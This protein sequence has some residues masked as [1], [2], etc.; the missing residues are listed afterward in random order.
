MTDGSPRPGA[1]PWLHAVGY[2]VVFFAAMGLGGF[3]FFL[4]GVA[5]ILIPGSVPAWVQVAY[6]AAGIAGS[7]AIAAVA[8]NGA[9]RLVSG[10]R[11]DQ[12][13]GRVDRRPRRVP[14]V[15]AWVAGI[16]GTVVASVL[17]AA[18]LNWIE[19]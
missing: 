18:A 6:V 9:F 11:D 10:R 17:S 3:L 8:A 7:V 15:L 4:G 12:P 13:A 5:I 19:R 14:A 1:R 2:F 16:L